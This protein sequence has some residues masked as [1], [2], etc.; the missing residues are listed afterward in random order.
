MC[1]LRWRSP[2]SARSVREE[3]V[4]C[5]A[6]QGFLSLEAADVGERGRGSQGVRP[7]SLL[8]AL[9]FSADAAGGEDLTSFAYSK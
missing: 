1:V 7:D 3:R 9:C 4:L 6:G 8:S 2:G 5:A